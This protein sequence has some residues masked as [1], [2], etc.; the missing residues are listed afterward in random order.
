MT[1]SGEMDRQP[2]ACVECGADR[3]HVQLFKSRRGPMC[4]AC[5]ESGCEQ[6]E[7][8]RLQELICAVVEDPWGLGYLRARE[9]AAAIVDKQSR[10]VTE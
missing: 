3:E 9:E 5:A 7:I 8:R 4:V 6:N 1:M 10:G 2:N